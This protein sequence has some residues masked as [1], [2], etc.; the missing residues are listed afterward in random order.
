MK[1]YKILKYKDEKLMILLDIEN[2]DEII[3]KI[4]FNKK[5][6]LN[7]KIQIND[8]DTNSSK[9]EIILNT[10]GDSE[11]CIIVG[12]KDDKQISISYSISSIAGI[13]II[14]FPNCVRI[15]IINF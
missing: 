6:N 13:S 5:I 14:D 15:K 7:K 10:E 4:D 2:S 8:V 12:D 3:D 9:F 11:F 1:E